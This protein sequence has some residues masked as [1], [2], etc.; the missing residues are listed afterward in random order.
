L[1]SSQRVRGELH[2]GALQQRT[3]ASPL[4]GSLGGSLILGLGRIRGLLPPSVR[5][6]DSARVC[7]LTGSFRGDRE[8]GYYEPSNVRKQIERTQL[9]HT[10]NSSDRV[11]PPAGHALSGAVAAALSNF[12]T[13]PFE[14]I[15]T[16]RKVQRVALAQRAERTR[17]RKGKRRTSISSSSDDEVRGILNV[18][19]KDEKRYRKYVSERDGSTRIVE[20]WEYEYDEEELYTGMWDAAQKIYHNE[21]VGGFYHGLWW[22]TLGSVTGGLAYFAACEYNMPETGRH[23]ETDEEP[24]TTC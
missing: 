24:Q 20:T 13:Y 23:A 17:K 5:D 7:Q 9:D 11:L 8:N 15:S 12:L 21:G 6:R 10:G 16:R 14:T 1:S 2:D 18:S 22:D 4:L 3:R 19:A